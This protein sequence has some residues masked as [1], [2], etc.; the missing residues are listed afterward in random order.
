MIIAH[1]CIQITA[2]ID[3]EIHIKDVNID[4]VSYPKNVNADRECYSGHTFWYTRLL[5][6]WPPAKRESQD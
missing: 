1:P 5:L 6:S 4:D 3:A 2:R